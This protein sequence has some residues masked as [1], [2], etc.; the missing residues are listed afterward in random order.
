MF[1]GRGILRREEHLL[2]ELFSRPAAGEADLD[3][4]AYFV[5]G[6][7]NAPVAVSFV[8]GKNI[9]FYVGAAGGY[10]HNRDSKKAF[11]V[12]PDGKVQSVH[13]KFLSPDRVPDPRPGARSSCQ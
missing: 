2:V 5:A 6:A 7:V 11:T 13:L 3:V 8:P 10:A 1:S 4:A 9:D 12:Q